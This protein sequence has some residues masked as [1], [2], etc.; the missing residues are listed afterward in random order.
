VRGLARAKDPRAVEPLIAC[1]QD[2]DRKMC[3]LANE[4]LVAIDEP[5]IT[6]FQHA[7]AGAGE[8]DK[9]FRKNLQQVFWNL[10]ARSE[11]TSNPPVGSGLE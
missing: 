4:A 7:L 5:A 3:N 10:G 8:K 11:D 6:P 1:F 2:E 9:Q